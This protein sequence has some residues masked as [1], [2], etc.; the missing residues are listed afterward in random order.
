MG[1]TLE[2]NA[3]ADKLIS[4]SPI[5][6]MGYNIDIRPYIN[7][8]KQKNKSKPNDSVILNEMIKLLLSKNEYF[9]LGL[10]IRDIQPILFKV[11]EYR[12][13]GSD[14]TE[15]VKSNPKNLHIKIDK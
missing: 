1:V 14:L 3:A 9:R 10:S 6:I 2:N 11:F 7:R 15:I 13:S 8:D 12:I 4:M 5:N